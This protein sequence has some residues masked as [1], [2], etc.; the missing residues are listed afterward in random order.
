MGT[1]TRVTRLFRS[2]GL[3]ARWNVAP[4]GQRC[5]LPFLLFPTARFQLG[6]SLSRCL[7][8]ANLSTSGLLRLPV[9]GRSQRRSGNRRTHLEKTGKLGAVGSAKSAAWVPSWS[10][11]IAYAVEVLIADAIV[12][13]RNILKR[14]RVGRQ[15]IKLR[16]QESDSSFELLVDHRDQRRPQWSDCARAT[17][18]HFLPIDQN[19]VTRHRVAVA[20][21]IGDTATVEGLRGEREALRDK[22]HG[23]V[24]LL[25]IT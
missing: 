21:D 25:L 23:H 19:V 4:S 2:I 1:I 11:V 22:S 18:L 12:P 6:L 13:H 10:R 17:L 24:G 8:T 5:A 7:C 9:F 20:G 15:R 16:F 3:P 14:T